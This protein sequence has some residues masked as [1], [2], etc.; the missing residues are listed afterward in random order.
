M[1]WVIAFACTCGFRWWKQVAAEKLR[2]RKITPPPGFQSRAPH[3]VRKKA[4]AKKQQRCFD[5]GS[6]RRTWCCRN[7]GSP[8]LCMDVSGI[9]IAVVKIARRRPRDV[10]GGSPNST[11]TPRAINCNNGS[12]VASVGACSSSGNAKRKSRNV[13]NASRNGYNNSLPDLPEEM[14]ATK[15]HKKRKRDFVVRNKRCGEK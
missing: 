14:I 5:G 12:C 2:K 8:F 11:A 1:E 6:S 4:A 15:R 9:G 3:Q 7:I 10:T 13:L